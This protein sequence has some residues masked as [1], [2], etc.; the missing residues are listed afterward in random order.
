[1]PNRVVV[2]G[3]GLVTPLGNTVEDSWSG[4]L[5]G[6]SGAARITKF[7][8]SRL[9]VQFACEVKGF[10]PLQFV[11]KKESRRY[12]LFVQY[13][14]GA[15]H[16]AVAQAGLDGKFPAPERTGVIIGS[17]IGGMVTFE[18]QTRLL[19]TKGPDRV[20]PFF[21]PMFIPDIAAG[22]VS[23]RYGLKGA[24]YA[25]VS[26]CA[27]SAHAIGQ[28][29]QLIQSGQ[30]DAMLT[31]GT[32][33][34]ISELAIAGF[35]N[36]R[37]LSTRND[38][39]ELASRPFD[40]ERD[41]FVLGDGAAMVMLESLEHAQA[42]GATILGEVL[43]YGLSGDAYHITSP[44]PNGE[45]AQ[46]A[47]RSCLADAGVGLESVG[48]I[49]AHGTSTAQGDIAETAAVKEV[50]GAQARKLIFGSTK[51]MT[52]HLLG[53]AGGLEFGVSLLV[54]RTGQ[55]PPTINQTTPD[56]ECDLD[57]APN[58]AVQRQVD[59]ALSNSFGFGGH[60]VTLAVRGWKG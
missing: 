21:I 12:D 16:E 43:G 36:M 19:V 13:A 33:A 42:R 60:N 30:A 32:E 18:E 10:D 22:L 49:N 17:G 50:F 54:A 9:Q 29:Y 52:G 25:T 15:A 23:I 28:S 51:S 58:T 3:L 46:R 7:D 31:G 11:D 40:K 8:P 44:A 37:A 39:P 47:M 38:A 6:R 2:T 27:S 5:A 48:Y 1:M 45:G 57:C 26:A 59:V 53:A 4:L 34:A 24:N 56:P 14:L 20:S 41:G 55:V 35:Q